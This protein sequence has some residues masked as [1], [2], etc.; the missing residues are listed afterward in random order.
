MLHLIRYI[1]YQNIAHVNMS[2]NTK[3]TVSVANHTVSVAKHT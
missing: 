2:R 1:S 3:H